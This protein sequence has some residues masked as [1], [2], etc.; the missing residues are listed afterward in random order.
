MTTIHLPPIPAT[1][2]RVTA[3][4]FTYDRDE[5]QPQ[6][7]WLSGLH[8]TGASLGTGQ[9]LDIAGDDGLEVSEP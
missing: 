8:T 7:W 3:H 4:G 6:R 9:L 5:Q 2:R 1:V